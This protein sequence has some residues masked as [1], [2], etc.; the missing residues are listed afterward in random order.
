MEDE[1]ARIRMTMASFVDQL[2]K[3]DAQIA[4]L[5]AELSR[6]HLRSTSVAP[7]QA[8]D[9]PRS[10]PLPQQQPQ[11]QFQ[12]GNDCN[13]YSMSDD[14]DLALSSGAGTVID[15]HDTEM[16]FGGG[17]F[18][19]GFGLGDASHGM[20]GGNSTPQYSD[21]LNAAQTLQFGFEEPVGF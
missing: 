12:G 13:N 21:Q 16:G 9:E 5:Q 19:S 8:S 10:S 14:D 6:Y 20:G 2:E 18:G 3:K 4:E 17:A 11:F 1:R 7:Y 15:G